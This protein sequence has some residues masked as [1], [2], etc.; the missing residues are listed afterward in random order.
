MKGKKLLIE[1]IVW[2]DLKNVLNEINMYVLNRYVISTVHY[3]I[4][5]VLIE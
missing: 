3:V 1:A 2:M 4:S 5:I